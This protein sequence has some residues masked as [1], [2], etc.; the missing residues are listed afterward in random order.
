MRIAVICEVCRGA[1][2]CVDGSNIEQPCLVCRFKDC[3]WLSCCICPHQRVITENNLEKDA[4]L[5]RA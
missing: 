5:G 2:G 4:H 1:T 3:P